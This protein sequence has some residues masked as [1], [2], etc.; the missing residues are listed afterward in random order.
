MF[1]F[2]SINENIIG[3]DCCILETC[4][5]LSHQYLKNP[6]RYFGTIMLAETDKVDTT[7]L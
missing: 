3:L 7:E 4:I 6:F 5:S 1:G 2:T